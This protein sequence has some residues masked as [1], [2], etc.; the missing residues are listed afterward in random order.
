MS[1]P[2][3][4]RLFVALC[5]VSLM[6]WWR[7]LVAVVELAL[8]NDAYT[9]ILLILPISVALI[10]MGWRSG[11]ECPEPNFLIGPT[12]MLSAILMGFAGGI[13]WA[14]DSVAAGA[15]LTLGMFAV[16]TWW[17]G[18]FVYCFG[19]RISRMFV[20]P[21]CFLLWLIPLPEFALTH[22]VAFLQQGS[23]YAA[24]L[25]FA[26]ARVPVMQDGVRLSIP[27]LTLE[28]AEECSSIRS[29]LMLVVTTMVL[30]HLLLRSAWAKGLVIL[31]AIPLAVAK[32]GF[33]VFTLAILGTYVDPSYLHGWLH[34]QGGV[35]FFLIFLGGLFVLFRLIGW[36]ENWPAARP[37]FPKAL[38][39][40]PSAAV[41]APSRM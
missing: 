2:S 26:I 38:S 21:L 28:I 9:H 7:T 20:F 24:R 17:I 39:S 25:L 6:L 8:Q 40:V 4:Y 18:S 12:L 22:V 1:P 32:N 29:S 3:P 13:W 35:V 16:V 41:D 15:R 5:L 27:G 31:A 34:H 30:A 10:V 37:E 19:T 33:R 14:A 11:K 23:A 36:A